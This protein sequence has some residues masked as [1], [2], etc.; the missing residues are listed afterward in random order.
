MPWAALLP[1]IAQVGLPLA[2]KIWQKAMSGKEVTQSDWDELHAIE[3]QT[4]MGH[5]QQI[6]ARLGLSMDDPKVQEIA[7]LIAAQPQG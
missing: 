7:K 3:K 1:L 4:P 6:A 2:E 5:L